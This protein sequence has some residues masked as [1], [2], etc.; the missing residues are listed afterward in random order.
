MS[1]NLIKPKK[2]SRPIT[3]ISEMDIR[4]SKTAYGD[5]AE[6]YTSQ[7]EHTLKSTPRL[8]SVQNL[9]VKQSRDFA[10]A[11]HRSRGSL[12]YPIERPGQNVTTPTLGM[13]MNTEHDLH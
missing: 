9:A 6:N 10:D 3:A 1:V 7:Q 2:V 8:G 12:R 4:D 5:P 13:T 11:V